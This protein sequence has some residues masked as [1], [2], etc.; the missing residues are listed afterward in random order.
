MLFM[1]CLLLFKRSGGL[2]YTDG[3][4]GKILTFLCDFLL[5]PLSQSS[6]FSRYTFLKKLIGPER[7]QQHWCSLPVDPLE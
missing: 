4:L 6:I 3:T 5:Y 2:V 7:D 1:P